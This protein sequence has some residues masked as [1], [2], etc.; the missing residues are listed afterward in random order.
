MYGRPLWQGLDVLAGFMFRLSRDPPSSQGRSPDK[1]IS[2]LGDFRK[3][4]LPVGGSMFESY[5]ARRLLSHRFINAHRG[6][7]RGQKSAW[8]TIGIQWRSRV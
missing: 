7:I 3:S 8:C 2:A 5:G 1:A 6:R 4:V